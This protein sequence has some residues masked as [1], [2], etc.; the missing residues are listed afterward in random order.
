MTCIIGLVES[1]VV[2]IGADSG[3]VCGNEVRVY[4]HPKVFRVGEFLIGYCGSVRESQVLRFHLY[5]E[6]RAAIQPKLE[7]MVTTFV[8]AV[9]T[10]LKDYGVSR[11]EN[12]VESGGYFLVGY[13]GHLYFFATDMQVSEYADGF[14]AIGSGAYYALGAMQ[15]LKDLS[16]RCRI[17]RALESSAYFCSGVMGPFSI[18]D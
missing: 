13:Q 3:L 1:G 11:I 17:Q 5:V 2:Y 8:E 18:W 16:P 9:R 10:C 6:P 14:H 4:A 7:Y 15:V 12:N